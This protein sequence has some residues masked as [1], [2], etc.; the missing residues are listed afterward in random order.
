MSD[1]KFVQ[2]SCTG[3]CLVES[4]MCLQKVVRTAKVYT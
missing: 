4:L 1:T 3:Q 2:L